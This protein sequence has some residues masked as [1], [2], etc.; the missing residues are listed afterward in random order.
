M[1]PCARPTLPLHT[2]GY[3]DVALGK[4]MI[5]SWKTVSIMSLKSGAHLRLNFN[6]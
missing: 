6:M 5:Y 3:Y 4:F 2:K 1:L